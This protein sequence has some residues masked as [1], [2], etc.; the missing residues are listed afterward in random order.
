[1]V[2]FVL[3]Q[4][5]QERKLLFFIQTFKIYIYFHF[6]VSSFATVAKTD[7]E[8]EEFPLRS[9]PKGCDRKDIARW[10]NSMHRDF[11]VNRY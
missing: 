9:M 4:K 2:P 11:T 6:Q 8:K 5:W 1:M 7:K 3:C 10:R